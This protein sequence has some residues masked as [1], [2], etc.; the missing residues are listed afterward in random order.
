MKKHT[1][2]ILFLT[3][4]LA[5]QVPFGI[6]MSTFNYPDILREKAGFV[7]TRFQELGPE[8]HLTWYLYAVSILLF[9]AANIK[10]H[11]ELKAT[12]RTAILSWGLASSFIQLIALLR[13]SFLVPV[14]ARAYVSTTDDSQRAMIGLIFDA[15][16]TYI[17][18]G[19]GEHLGQATMAIWSLLL[20]R[21]TAARHP[22][23]RT[24]GVTSAALLLLGLSEHLLTVRGIHVEHLDKLAAVGFTLW[25]IWQLALGVE[26]LRTPQR[27]PFSA[28]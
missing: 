24:L 14:L 3:F 9:I 1:L 28:S 23:L 6:L 19:I 18:I 22:I 15:Q 2:G 8:L 17:G 26:M 13:W 5:V 7:L 10:L 25:S 12:D 16:N 4:P 21:V 11:G 27:N 20:A